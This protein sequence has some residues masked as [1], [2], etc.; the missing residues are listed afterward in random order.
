MKALRSIIYLQLTA[1]IISGTFLISL[2][3]HFPS[4]IREE[5][6]L[7]IAILLTIMIVI[8]I[9]FLIAILVVMDDN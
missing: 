3:Y 5:T 4:L 9:A 2:K 1:L 7:W 6:I 8:L